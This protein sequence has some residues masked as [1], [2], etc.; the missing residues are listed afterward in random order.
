MRSNLWRKTYDWA[1]ERWRLR[2]DAVESDSVSAAGCS[3]AICDRRGRPVL[4]DQPGKAVSENRG[5]RNSPPKGW[6]P[7]FCPGVRHRGGFKVS[8]HV[9]AV[10]N[11]EFL[12]ALFCDLPDD[13]AAMLC[14]FS[15]DPNDESGDRCWKWSARQWHHGAALPANVGPNVNSYVAVS[16]FRRN[17]AGE[18]RRRK[19]QFRRLHA[20]MIDD[21]NTK[22]A[23]ARLRLAPSAR[24]ETSPA[25][26]QDYLFIETTPRTMRS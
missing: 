16:S 15:G 22:V 19:D 17:P 7:K 14:G 21:V 3:S 23:A 18:Y 4:E 1:I 20:V 25:N 12:E 5:R 6:P 26:F 2:C 13:A 8:G 9:I 24:I 10:T 11:V